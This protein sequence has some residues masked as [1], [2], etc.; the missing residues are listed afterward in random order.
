M[1][2]AKTHNIQINSKVE[3]TTCTCYKHNYGYTSLTPNLLHCLH[4]AYATI[5]G[6]KVTTFDGVQYDLGA[7]CSFLLAR[8]FVDGNFSLVLHKQDNSK[9]ILLMADGKAITIL[10]DGKV[11]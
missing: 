10:A 3:P 6:D 8:D 2:A 1:Q 5:Q 4:T 7:S 9:N 11:K